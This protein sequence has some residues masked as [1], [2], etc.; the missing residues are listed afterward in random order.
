MVTPIT[1]EDLK[2]AGFSPIKTPPSTSTSA[3]KRNGDGHI[4]AGI[5]ESVDTLEAYLRNHGVT[6]T[7]RKGDVIL[8][9]CVFDSSHGSK[10]SDCGTV[11]Y[12]DGIGYACQHASCSGRTWQDVRAA[13]DPEWAAKRNGHAGH[14]NRIGADAA[15]AVVNAFVPDDV[16]VSVP[17]NVPDNG[18]RVFDA[19]DPLP[20]ARQVVADRYMH[21][22]GCRTILYH[23]GQ[24]WEWSDGR[25]SP[26]EPE[27]LDGRLYDYL[28]TAF[29]RGR[30]GPERFKPTQAKID[31]VVDALRAV[32]YLPKEHVPSCWLPVGREAEFAA[33]DI[34]PMKSRLVHL[35]SMTELP[36]TPEFYCTYSLPFDLDPD[37]PKPSRWLQLMDEIWPDDA[38][39]V[40][41][42]RRWFG[43]CLTPDTREQ[44][45][46]MLVGPTRSGKGTISRVL[47]D[48]LG[49]ANVAWPMAT[50]LVSQFGLTPLIGKS[51][52]VIPDARFDGRSSGLLER[53]LSLSGGDRMM[54]D[55]KNREPLDFLPTSRLVLLT[56]ELPR[57]LD[58]SGALAGRMIPLV[59]R[60]SFLG[61]EDLDLDT[62]LKPEL[63]GILNWAIEGWKELRKGARLGLPLS[64]RDA[65]QEIEDLS[66]PVK[67]FV[68]H[69]CVL[70]DGRQ[71]TADGLY[72]AWLSWCQEQGRDRSC[73]KDV[74]CKDLLAAVPSLRKI[75]PR[76]CGRQVLSYAGIGLAEYGAEQVV[77]SAHDKAATV[78]GTTPVEREWDY[79]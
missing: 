52:A 64:S 11:W 38:E 63:P 17:D 19:A 79:G 6:V 74:F 46:L 15:V 43:Y 57:I 40:A 26:L 76:I 37:A 71:A 23:G 25:Y 14:H 20:T 45:M 41:V 30:Y 22:S 2:A 62:K 72:K 44:K 31:N 7:G 54:A 53:L 35:P 59:M 8:H 49:K 13:I 4:P 73:I 77:P 47:T 21:D 69:C 9:E 55:R 60:Q 75:H 28:D 36:L 42:L 65:V 33:G 34:L 68:R 16:P 67:A 5:A 29:S 50:N 48:L 27:A 70:G 58:P 61:R 18:R 39:A 3:S 78:N 51:L 24:F 12:S 1:I 66:S 10:G 56:N 32:A